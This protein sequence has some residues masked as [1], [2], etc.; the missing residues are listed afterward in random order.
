MHVNLSTYAKA[1]SLQTMA[2]FSGKTL[3]LHKF[4]MVKKV[5]KMIKQIFSGNNNCKMA[6]IG[7]GSQ[8][9]HGQMW[10]FLENA[11]GLG[12]ILNGT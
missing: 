8:N 3:G 10:A 5:H 11:P 2:V 7:K 12:W 4:W 6:G 1:E 9:V